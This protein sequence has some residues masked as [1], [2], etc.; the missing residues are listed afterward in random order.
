MCMYILENEF[1]RIN[2]CLLKLLCNAYEVCNLMF[3]YTS[4]NSFL[5]SSISVFLGPKGTDYHSD[6]SWRLML[7]C[8]GSCLAKMLCLTTPSQRVSFNF[9]VSFQFVLEFANGIC[10]LKLWLNN[11]ICC[12]F[13]KFFKH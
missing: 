8:I 11:F 7:Q 6:T 3:F 1:F 9:F 2:M 10:W 5:L 12:I 4:F 13:S